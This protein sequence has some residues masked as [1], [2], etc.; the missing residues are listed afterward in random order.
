MKRK[1]SFFA[2]GILWSSPAFL[3]MTV[4]FICGLIAGGSTGLLGRETDSVA[5]LA[6]YLMQSARS[7][8]AILQ[9]MLVSAAGAAAWLAVCLAAGLLMPPSLFVGAAVA[10]RGFSLAFA[11]A[12]MVAQLGLRGI[13]LSFCASGAAAIITVP[14]LLLTATASYLAA[15]D[16]PKGQRGG[17]MYALGR[18][19]GALA[20]CFVLS[21][22]AAVLRAGIAP[23]LLA[24]M[25]T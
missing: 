23:I 11:V 22:A 13:A 15:A 5:R 21:V 16:A 24:A 19:R 8:P 1:V 2:V 14:C 7:E 17:Y 25:P 10:A 9:Q 18:Y 6:E 4:L 20:L 12:T 3:F